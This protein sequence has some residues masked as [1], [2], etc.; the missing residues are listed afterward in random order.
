MFKQDGETVLAPARSSLEDLRITLP[1]GATIYMS[2]DGNIIIAAGS[3]GN[4]I[5]N[6]NGDPATDDSGLVSSEVELSQT[7]HSHN[8]TG[9]P[10][11]ASGKTMG[12][13]D[14]HTSTLKSD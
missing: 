10:P 4:I 8:F 1:G 12:E 6:A 11:G 5:F 7:G 3:G 13:T 9:M 14:K 2:N